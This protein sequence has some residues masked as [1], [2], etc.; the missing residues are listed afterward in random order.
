MC[1][2]PP[3]ATVEAIR[4]GLRGRAVKRILVLLGFVLGAYL[5]GRAIAEPFTIDLTDPASYREDWG[6]PT[7]FGVL[8]VHCGPGIAAAV[9]LVQ[10]RLRRSG[11]RVV[12]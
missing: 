7:L 5:I 3:A 1:R 9:L 8:V 12:R 4:T 10:Y 11:K 6:G 2:G